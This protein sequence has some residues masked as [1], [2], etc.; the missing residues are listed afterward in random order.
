MYTAAPARLIRTVV[1]GYGMF[2]GGAWSAPKARTWL[3]DGLEEE[4]DAETSAGGRLVLIRPAEPRGLAR[5]TFRVSAARIHDGRHE[6][7]LMDEP[8]YAQTVLAPC[9]C[10]GGAVAT[11]GPTDERHRVV[12][13][14][15]V[16]AWV[17]M[18][19]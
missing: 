19:S 18:V 1:V 3:L 7:W 2:S 8:G 16:P 6:Y 10:G 14:A 9:G 12:P 5:D 11:A 13:V 4:P 17:E 15:R